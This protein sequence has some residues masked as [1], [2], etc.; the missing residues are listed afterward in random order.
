MVWTGSDLN[1]CFFK[2]DRIH[3]TLVKNCSYCFKQMSC[4]EKPTWCT[5][6]SWYILSTFTCIRCICTHHQE[7]QPYV[8]NIWYLLFLLGDCLLFWMDWN[9]FQSIQNNRLSLGDCR[10]NWGGRIQASGPTTS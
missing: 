6:Y 5:T 4:K 1:D 8:Y 10:R 2:S 9:L 3:S 7:V